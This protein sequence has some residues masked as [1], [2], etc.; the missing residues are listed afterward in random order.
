MANTYSRRKK[1]FQLVHDQIGTQS[2][3]ET[4]PQNKADSK[5]L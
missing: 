5:K 4:K 2:V 3:V 1:R